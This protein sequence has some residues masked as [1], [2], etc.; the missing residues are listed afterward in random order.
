[1]KKNCF[2]VLMAA[3]WM[4]ASCT[5][6][7]IPDQSSSDQAITIVAHVSPQSK[8]P[9]LGADGSGSFSK[10]DVM[11]LCVS[12]SESENL[13]VDY[14]YQENTLTWGG[15]N[16]P[17]STSEVKIA[18]CYPKQTVAKDGTFQFDVLTAS[19]Q[20]LLLSKAQTVKVG[21]ADAVNL[22]FEHALH[23]LDLTFTP[24][25]G[26]SAEDLKKLSLSVKASTQCTVDAFKGEFK[27]LKAGEGQYTSTGASASFYLIPQATSNVTLDVTIGEQSKTLVLS[28]LFTQ[29]GNSQTDLK[30]GAKCTITLKVGRE[31]IVVESGSIGAWENQVTVDGELTI[32]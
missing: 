23:R 12:K 10:G 5:N 16:L 27:D 4:A 22:N 29:L 11:T 3:A 26:Y 25:N 24:G 18:A 19:Y 30:G 6:N 31:G 1:M 15:L 28:E 2:Y 13:S 14:A 32:G 17:E 20:D 8:A 9:Q 21:T 7:E